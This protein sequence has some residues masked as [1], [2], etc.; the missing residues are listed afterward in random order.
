M[1]A[2]RHK[3]PRLNVLSAPDRLVQTSICDLVVVGG[4]AGGIPALISLLKA[5]P[6]DFPLPILVVQHLSRKVPSRLPEVLQWHTRWAVKW[7][8]DGEPIR[9]GMVYVGPADRHL[10]VEPDQRLVLS[11]A[12]PVGWWRPAVD[13]LFQSAAEVYGER[14]A[15][16][17]LSGAMW[18]GAKGMAAVASQGGI[19]IVQDEATC[20][21]F[22]MPACALDLGRADL[23]MS[24][25]KI[26][27][28]LQA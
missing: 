13:A 1:L 27:E 24:P 16:V 19:T 21:H 2:S 11:S 5:L 26:A 3:N 22:D 23:I 28:V 20:G 8:E 7:A 12:P 25:G 9:P 15:A 4:S 17:V 14:V 18:D 6:T 10:L